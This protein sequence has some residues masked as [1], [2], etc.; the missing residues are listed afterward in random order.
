MLLYHT[1]VYGIGILNEYRSNHL[2]GYFKS[3]H[4]LKMHVEN[5]TLT[6]TDGNNY[7]YNTTNTLQLDRL[8]DREYTIG[9]WI[10]LMDISSTRFVALYYQ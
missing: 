7:I 2:L 1:I 6:G 10:K 8:N 4:E 5:S 3:Y 9:G